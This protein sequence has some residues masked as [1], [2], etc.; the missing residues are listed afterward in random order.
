MEKYKDWLQKETDSRHAKCKLCSK[1]IDISNMGEAALTSHMKG[2]KHATAVSAAKTIP[3][4]VFLGGANATAP[5][6]SSTTNTT[7][8][9]LDYS[10][11]NEVMK[12]EIRWVLKVLN[13]HYSYKSSEDIAKVFTDMFPDSKI[14][15]QFSCG[16]KKCA[17]IAAFG[18]E[19]YFKRLLLKEV[20]ELFILVLA[21]LQA[22]LLSLHWDTLFSGILKELYHH[23]LAIQS[24]NYFC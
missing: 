2:K 19:P 11:K 22:Y 18:L 23:F 1:T 5:N 12:A 14:A 9:S 17:Y 3:I 16:E 21:K 13:S 4:N 8:A 10:S 20:S 6:A 7:Q 24:S 15:S